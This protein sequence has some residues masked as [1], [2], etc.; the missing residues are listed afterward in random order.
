[1]ELQDELEQEDIA[2]DIAALDKEEILKLGED[3]EREIR[4]LNITGETMCASLHFLI[5]ESECNTEDHSEQ[6][7][8]QNI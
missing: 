2:A 5:S 3:F 7:T 8:K 1:M 6:T 4:K